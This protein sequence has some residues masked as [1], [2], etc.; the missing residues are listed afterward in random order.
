MTWFFPALAGLRSAPAKASGAQ[1][2][3]KSVAVLL[4]ATH[5]DDIPLANTLATIRHSAV[6]ASLSHPGLELRVIVGA[7]GCGG[8][9]AQVAAHWGAGIV[10]ACR[11]IGR[12]RMLRRLVAES[13]AADWVIVARPGVLWPEDLLEKILPQ[14]RND[15][16]VAIGPSYRCP[17]GG[18]LQRAYW[19]LEAR[20]KQLECRLGGP[21]SLHGATVAYRGPELREAVR[22]LAGRAWLNED[23]VIP[24]AM[25]TANPGKRIR[26]LAELNVYDQPHICG[27]DAAVKNGFIRRL[28]FVAGNVQWIR[29]LFCAVWKTNVR[30][31]ILAMRRIFRVFWVY[32]FLSLL[33][34]TAVFLSDLSGWPAID[35]VLAASLV[36]L[37]V[38]GMKPFRELV[39]A[40]LA[41]LL[42]PLCL[43][44][45]PSFERIRE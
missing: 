40:A 1:R 30:V 4:P 27:F 19:R 6:K 20:V 31:G 9:T 21:V 43:I 29:E 3:I 7:D 36:T 42:A 16:L 35:L 18:V 2:D 5:G 38:V 10:S 33:V 28:M 8:K 22:G 37:I 23:V 44:Y 39:Q 15:D 17:Q 34:P 32:W 24:L 12:W 26:Y 14:F 41:S 11:R 13:R 45:E 25:R